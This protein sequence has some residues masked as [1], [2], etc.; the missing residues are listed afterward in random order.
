MKT[1]AVVGRIMTIDAKTSRWALTDC[2]PLYMHFPPTSP[3]TRAVHFKS[4][5][6]FQ[7]GSP[8]KVRAHDREL[9]INNVIMGAFSI[10]NTF[11]S[12]RPTVGPT[13][14]TDLVNIVD[15]QMTSCSLFCGC[16]M[17]EVKVR[18]ESG[19]IDF[20]FGNRFHFFSACNSICNRVLRESPTRAMTNCRRSRRRDKEGAE[21]K[22]RHQIR[23]GSSSG[24]IVRWA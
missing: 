13:W 16:L 22:R 10:R 6:R 2:K 8:R 9:V 11:H 20:G 7:L 17:G 19:K 24:A 18:W 5:M 15:M 3:C 14:S 4:D 23:G 21:A 12:E 1:A